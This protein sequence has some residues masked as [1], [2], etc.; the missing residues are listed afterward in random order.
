[1]ESGHPP[2]APLGPMPGK[3]FGWRVCILRFCQVWA[4]ETFHSNCNTSY[5]YNGSKDMWCERFCK[6]LKFVDLRSSL[7]AQSGVLI[8]FQLIDFGSPG[9]NF[10]LL[11]HF[12]SSSASFSNAASTV[13]YLVAKMPDISHRS[14]WKPRQALLNLSP[15]SYRKV[16]LH[17]SLFRVIG[18]LLAAGCESDYWK[19]NQSYKKSDYRSSICYKGRFTTPET[20]I[21]SPCHCSQIHD[22]MQL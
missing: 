5:I 16:R 18:R 19:Q 12:D 2:L 15:R 11:V 8:S 9:H 6:Y 7:S 22:V 4:T 21:P 20:D 3:E 10:T 1:M 17:L 14:F 13:D